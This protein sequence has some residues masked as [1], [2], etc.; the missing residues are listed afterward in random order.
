VCVQVCLI[1]EQLS[2]NRIILELD[3]KGAVSSVVTSS[4]HERKS[5]TVIALRAGRLQLQHNTIGDDVPVVVILRALGVTSDQ[6]ICSMIG[7]E[8]ELQDALSASLEEA[9]ALGVF[10]QTAALEYIGGEFSTHAGT[11]W[12]RGV[13]LR[14][15]WRWRARRVARLPLALQRGTAGGLACAQSGAAAAGGAAWQYGLTAG[16]R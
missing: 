5:R 1:Q 2:K 12:R 7:P 3:G 9:S 11:T 13:A 8:P 15:G 16:Q 10:S 14:V 6:E 4:T